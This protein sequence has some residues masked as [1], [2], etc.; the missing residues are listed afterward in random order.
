MIMVMTITAMVTVVA[1]R[2]EAA[3][4]DNSEISTGP[5]FAGLF[6]FRSFY[7]IILP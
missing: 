4:S 2:A 3:P 5:H 7:S 1:V 6:I